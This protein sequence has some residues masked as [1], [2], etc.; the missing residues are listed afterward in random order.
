MGAL[1]ANKKRNALSHIVDVIE[2]AVVAGSVVYVSADGVL[3]GAF[4]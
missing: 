4:D 3:C 1:N 2:Q